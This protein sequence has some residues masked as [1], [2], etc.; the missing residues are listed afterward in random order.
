MRCLYCG[1]ELALLK[2]WTGG[3][4]FCSD[5]H[6]QR[7]QEEYNQLALNRL[8][9]AKPPG[10]RGNEAGKPGQ[11]V[12]DADVPIPATSHPEPTPSA[13][14][15]AFHEIP[16]PAAVAVH[17][18]RIVVSEPEPELIHPGLIEEEPAPP[19]VVAPADMVGFL[20]VMPDAAPAEGPQVST[21][22]M[23]FLHAVAAALPDHC[24]EPLD[25]QRNP[26][27]LETAGL[28]TFQ[29]SNRASNYSAGS[30]ERRLEVRDFV[31]TD[32]VVEIS[33]SPA[34]E[35]GLE[36]SSN[37][38]DI[39]IFP[40]PPQGSALGWQ[41]PPVSF[42]NAP[43][44]LGDLARLAFLTT[45]FAGEAEKLDEIKLVEPQQVEPSNCAIED[46]AAVA[47]EEAP[48]EIQE[49]PHVEALV[50]PVLQAV[51]EVPSISE[52]APAT[53]AVEPVVPEVVEEKV[54]EVATKP[55]PLTL[56]ATAPGKG[57]PVQVFSSAP[58][59]VGVQL[60][61]SSSLPLRPTMTIGPT[62]APAQR[63]AASPAARPTPAPPSAKIE[64]K[65]ETK[66]EPK[67]PAALAEPVPPATSVK[68]EAKIEPRKPAPVRPD[69]RVAAPKTQTEVKPQPEAKPQ[70]EVK[71][72]KKP[73]PVKVPEPVKQVAK[74]EVPSPAKPPAAPTKAEAKPEK[75]PEMKETAKQKE[76][77]KPVKAEPPK[78][79]AKPDLRPVPA[80]LAASTPSDLGLPRL[81]LSSSPG[82]LGQIP[83]IARIAIVVV[84]LA[85]IG[86]LIV[87]SSK[88]GGAAIASTADTS[89]NV[90]AGSPLPAGDAG[91]ITD[92]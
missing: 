3:G 14:K 37:A 12:S 9:Q 83:M 10:K 15:P 11:E 57:K 6:R 91:W 77:D 60:P 48:E 85:G 40:R 30:R 26:Y 70:V 81:N 39:L 72:V 61:R 79:D 92:W 23:E 80:F 88:S 42:A 71:D 22:A 51:V 41:E 25:S 89:S 53:A 54:P 55:L 69:P 7:Y 63:P 66:T 67:K 45:G 82:L 73:A 52:P 78:P 74:A 34:G 64:T 29:P 33:L 87:F 84:L 21:P 2:R 27:Q 86:A 35:T 24:F 32:P 18:E 5:G 65:I 68:M 36:T 44:E 19:E 56:H 1:K 8:L 90:V 31:R 16:Q 62:P 28:L 38:M 4:E 47:V 59:V 43:V 46:S 20:V 17:E 75:K 49:N 50:E 76:E 58:K 13:A